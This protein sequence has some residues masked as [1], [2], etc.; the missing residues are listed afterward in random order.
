MGGKYKFLD[1]NEDILDF[2]FKAL[3]LM[4]Q[5]K[6]ASISIL[7]FISNLVFRLFQKQQREILFNNVKYSNMLL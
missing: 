5:F 2:F 7:F 1:E 3:I 4:D 6:I